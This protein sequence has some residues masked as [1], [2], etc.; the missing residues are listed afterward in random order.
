[1]SALDVWNDESL[2]SI[3]GGNGLLGHNGFDH[4]AKGVG[5]AVDGRSVLVTYLIEKKMDP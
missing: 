1:M 4:L 5:A 2:L 3:R